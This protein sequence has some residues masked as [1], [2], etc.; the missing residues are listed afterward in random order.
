MFATISWELFLR[1]LLAALLI[2]YLVVL[3][4]CW[5]KEIRQWLQQRK[6]G[7]SA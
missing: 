7:E 4:I 3:G 1:F 5:R 6:S 2:Y